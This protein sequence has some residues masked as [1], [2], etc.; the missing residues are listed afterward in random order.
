MCVYIYIYINKYRRHMKIP[1][2]SRSQSRMSLFY[3]LLTNLWWDSDIS[4]FTGNDLWRPGHWVIS[5]AKTW[6]PSDL[7]IFHHTACGDHPASLLKLEASTKWQM[8]LVCDATLNK[9]KGDGWLQQP[10]PRPLALQSLSLSLSLNLLTLSAAPWTH[11]HL[12]HGGHH[13]LFQLTWKAGYAGQC[14]TM[15]YPC[16]GVDYGQ[17]S[18]ALFCRRLQAAVIDWRLAWKDRTKGEQRAA[19]Q[20]THDHNMITCECWDFGFN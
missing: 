6:L 18:Q 3:V 14:N 4:D 7:P 9:H 16:A 2:S 12:K 13:D 8:Q 17:D 15:W 19:D 20:R 5:I 1:F 11:D 10:W